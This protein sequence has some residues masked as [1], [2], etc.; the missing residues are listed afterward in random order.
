[1]ATSRPASLRAQERCPNRSSLGDR[2]DLVECDPGVEGGD[3]GVAALVGAEM[4][5]ADASAAA[6]RDRTPGSLARHWKASACLGWA[7]PF[8]G[9]FAFALWVVR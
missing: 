5:A 9:A 4:A 6:R 2:S 3:E 8:L 7:A 1:M